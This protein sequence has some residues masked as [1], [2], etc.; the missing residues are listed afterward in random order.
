[1]SGQW[2]VCV[3]PEA[4]ARHHAKVY[5]KAQVGAPPMSVPH[6]DTRIVDGQKTLL[7][8]PY[9][10]FSTKFLKQG[11]YFDLPYSVRPGNVVPMIMSGVHNLSL[12][13]YLVREVLQSSERR[14]RTLR[15]YYPTAKAEDWELRVAGQRVQVIHKDPKTGTYLQFGTEV[16][17][18]A[19]G[20]LSA[21]LGASPGASTSVAIVV[22][23]L[24]RCFPQQLATPG[25][26]AKLRQ[27]IPSFGQSL[28]DDPA[29]CRR[30]RQE[31][32]EVLGLAA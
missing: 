30:V 14:F 10:G 8:G 17:N 21:L 6:L 5:G 11:S 22:E 26:Q 2:L 18:S 27:M 25:W 3:N 31:T 19:D 28:P 20:T 13:K 15:E 24:A 9:A 16:V 7:F 12:V 29:L 23:L 4:I 32:S 1:M